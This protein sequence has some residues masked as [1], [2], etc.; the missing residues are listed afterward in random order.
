VEPVFQTEEPA[1]NA[2]AAR[3]LELE[4]EYAARRGWSVYKLESTHRGFV[5]YFAAPDAAN[6]YKSA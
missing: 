6:A 1:D 2:Y 5:T 3:L 4:T